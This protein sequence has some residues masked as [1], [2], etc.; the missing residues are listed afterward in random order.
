M[1]DIYIAYL[2]F[3]FLPNDRIISGLLVLNDQNYPKD[4]RYSTSDDI[5]P[6]QRA[7]YGDK[8]SSYLIQSSCDSL[9]DKLEFEPSYIVTNNILDNEILNSVYPFFQAVFNQ[10]ETKLRALN[11]EAQQ[12]PPSIDDAL[13]INESFKRIENALKL[14]IAK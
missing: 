14:L 5:N 8:L 6:V 2:Y 10:G 9:L 13:V 3:R 7:L 12:I 11:S 1:K 4:F